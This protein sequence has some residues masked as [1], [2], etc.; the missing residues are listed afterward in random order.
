[1]NTMLS[2]LDRLALALLP[3]VFGTQRP[4]LLTRLRPRLL[5]R[6]HPRRRMGRWGDQTTISA[7]LARSKAA[8]AP[9]VLAHG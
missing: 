9:A 6:P 8:A 5:G 7:A 3:V 4:T 2:P 1:M